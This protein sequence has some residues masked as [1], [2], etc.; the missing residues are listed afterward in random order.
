[1]AAAAMAFNSGIVFAPAMAIQRQPE[2]S[3]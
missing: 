1:M 3:E 2:H